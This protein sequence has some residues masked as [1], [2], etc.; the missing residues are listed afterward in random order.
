M[1]PTIDP[2]LQSDAPVVKHFMVEVIRASVTREEPVFSQMAGNV[3]GNMDWWLAHPHDA[4]HLKACE[5]GHVVGVI[6]VKHHWNLCSLFI[7]PER[8]GQGLGTR[9]LQAAI[10]DCTDKAPDGVIRLNA[11]PEAIAFYARHGFQPRESRQSLP[12]GFLAMELKLAP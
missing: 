6:L 3:E 10:R 5:D 12:T 8:Q 1:N 4:V 7:A 2:V 9:L 11:A